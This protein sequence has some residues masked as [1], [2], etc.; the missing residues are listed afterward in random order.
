MSDIKSPF[1]IFPEFLSP[2]VVSQITDLVRFI[3]PAV[4]KDGYPMVSTMTHETAEQLIY[5]RLQSELETIANHF[6]VDIKGIH[7]MTFNSCPEGGKGAAEAPHCE[8]SHYTKR[9]WV[10]VK[11]ID[12]TAV[13]WLKDFQDRTPLDPR[14]EVYGG[15]LEFPIYNFGFQ[16]QRGTM[17]V[18][19][20]GP[21]FISATSQVLVGSLEYVRINFTVRV[22]DS[23]QIWLY[24]PEN[25]KGDIRSWFADV[26]WF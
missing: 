7:H 10:K 17:V 24:Q 21:H 26:G 4:D 9:K 6:N 2:K 19:P 8:N 23:E 14:I 13:L 5:Q 22:K 25:F 11:D 1:L 20:A 16:P 15:K 18:Y 12:L 3:E